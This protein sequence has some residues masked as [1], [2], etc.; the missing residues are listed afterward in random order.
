M[1]PAHKQQS[2]SHFVAAI[3]SDVGAKVD[4]PSHILHVSQVHRTI[5]AR[6]CAQLNKMQKKKQ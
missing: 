5:A 1:H 3:A 6:D 4:I 2:L